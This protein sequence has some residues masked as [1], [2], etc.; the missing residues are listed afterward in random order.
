MVIF[1]FGLEALFATVSRAQSSVDLTLHQTQA[2]IG[3]YNDKTSFLVFYR[4]CV[5]PGKIL[6][7]SNV[8]IGFP[9]YGLP[10]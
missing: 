4:F 6:F 7:C 8:V 1:L 9:L 5:G 2:A 10:I 3:P